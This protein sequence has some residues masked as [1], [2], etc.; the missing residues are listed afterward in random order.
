[1][2]DFVYQI[3]C[4]SVWERFDEIESKFIKGEDLDLSYYYFL[5]CAIN[6]LAYNK[7][8]GSFNV[9]KIEKFL[10]DS[11]FRKKYGKGKGNNI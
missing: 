5:Q 10:N 3:N 2:N 1:M 4:Y 8:I 6:T 9:N 7:G 11:D